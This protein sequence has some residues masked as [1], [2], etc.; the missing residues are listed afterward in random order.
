LTYWKVDDI[1]TIFRYI[2]AQAKEATFDKK[3]LELEILQ[4]M[5]LKQVRGL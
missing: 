3:I 2:M 5:P 1:L 4:W